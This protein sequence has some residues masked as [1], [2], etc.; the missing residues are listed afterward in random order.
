M[1][2]RIVVLDKGIEKKELLAMACCSGAQ[3]RA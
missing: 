3:L 1:G 2:A